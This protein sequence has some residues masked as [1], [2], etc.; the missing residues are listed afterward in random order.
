MGRKKGESNHTQKEL[1][2]VQASVTEELSYGEGEWRGGDVL[3][4]WNIISGAR[5]L[6]FN[7]ASITDH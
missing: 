2:I 6:A 5:L 4:A 3:G 1:I 7:L